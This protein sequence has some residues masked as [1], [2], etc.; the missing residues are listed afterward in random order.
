MCE[1]RGLVHRNAMRKESLLSELR[2]TLRDEIGQGTQPKGG[3]RSLRKSVTGIYV[4]LMGEGETRPRNG[5]G[6]RKNREMGYW[7]GFSGGLPDTGENVEEV[8]VLNYGRKNAYSIL[9]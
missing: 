6:V 8:E 5:C 1:I 2:N 9:A 4:K 7:K 3:N